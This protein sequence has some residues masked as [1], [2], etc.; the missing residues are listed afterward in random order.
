MGAF[1]NLLQSY[2][3]GTKHDV[4]TWR[5]S[6]PKQLTQADEDEIERK[7]F[8]DELIK[9]TVHHGIS[10]GDQI[11]KTSFEYDDGTYDEKSFE[12]FNTWYK[13]WRSAKTKL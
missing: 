5:R 7:K 1:G 8:V 12:E 4:S 6:E 11:D 3:G 9:N 2:F 13:S 10:Y